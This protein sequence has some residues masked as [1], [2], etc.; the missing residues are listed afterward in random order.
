MQELNQWKKEA[1][2]V[3][4]YKLQ[5]FFI[6]SNKTAQILLLLIAFIYIYIHKIYIT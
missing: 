6:N 5:S 4:M 3:C 1:E 2:I